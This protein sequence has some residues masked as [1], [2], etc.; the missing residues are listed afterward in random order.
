MVNAREYE[1]KNKK[2]LIIEHLAI[3]PIIY[4]FVARI[5]FFSLARRRGRVE[6]TDDVDILSRLDLLLL[7]KDAL[8]DVRESSERELRSIVE[9]YPDE[10][11]SIDLT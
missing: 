9:E 1:L 4:Y 2:K 10:I 5:C 8:E 7:R 11:S 3:F 6:A